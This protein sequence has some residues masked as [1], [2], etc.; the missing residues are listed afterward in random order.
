MHL[1][2]GT[3]TK[4]EKGILRL[5]LQADAKAID[6][7]YRHMVMKF[8]TWMEENVTIEDY[9]KILLKIPGSMRKDVP[10][11]KDR[12]EEIEAANHF[13]CSA[14]L[15]YYYTWFNCFVLKIILE[16][17]KTDKDRTEILSI[18]QS[19]TEEVHKYCK[20]NIFECPPPS[21]MSSTKGNTYFV[22]KLEQHHVLDENKFTAEEIGLVEMTLMTCF[23][24]PE[25]I[26][27]LCTVTDG[28]VEL[29]YSVPLCIYSVLF[30]LN[31]EKWKHLITL[32][33]TEII[34]K[35]YHYKKEHV[36]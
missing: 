14:I 17:A 27:K 13:K 9:R 30:P 34:T 2:I 8:E 1:D 26:L 18:L 10:M 21:S 23:E 11:L 7:K 12:W 5:K 36:S 15:S 22:L 19:Y 25:Y 4:N 6:K 33:V 31:E 32:C 20:R 3:L 24:I 16:D 29:M 28:C 35:D